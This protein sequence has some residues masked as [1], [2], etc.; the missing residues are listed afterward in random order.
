M[1]FNLDEGI[2]VLER[3]PRI[4]N[5]WLKDLPPAWIAVNE[6]PNTW[7]AYDIVGHL[8]N[9]EL[10]DWIPRMK[11]ILSDNPNK[12]FEPFDRFAQE[13]NSQGKTLDQLLEQFE[14]LRRSNLVYLYDCRLNATDLQKTGVHPT[15]GTVTLSQ[16]LATWVAHDLNHLAQLARVM[17]NRYR[18]DVGPWKEFLGVMNLSR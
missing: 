6:G 2:A 8:I 11:I 5:T 3:T 10:T 7:N 4:L 17:A 18:T 13:R 1:Q 16:L 15:F 12:N 14:S 9:G